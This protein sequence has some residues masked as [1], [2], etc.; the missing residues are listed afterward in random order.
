MSDVVGDSIA[1]RRF[2]TALLAMFSGLALVLAGIGIYGVIS[3]GVSQRTYEIGVRM[4][5]GASPV[6]IRRMVIG[7]G[8]RMTFVGLG[9]GLA[10]AAAVDRLLRSLLFGVS[11]TD[12]M[13]LAAVALA[14]FAVA[15]GASAGP[16]RRAT[17]VNP[18]EALRNG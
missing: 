12:T 8:A 10:G 17:A 14:L 11:P 1:S 13:T 15:A 5:M 7:E 9:V 6:A 2:A 3:F 4:A 18:T 16:A